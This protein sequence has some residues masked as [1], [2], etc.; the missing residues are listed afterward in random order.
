MAHLPSTAKEALENL[1]N[2]ADNLLAQSDITLGFAEWLVS[3]FQVLQSIYGVDSKEVQF[4]K[5]IRFQSLFTRILPLESVMRKNYRK[6]LM[7]AK[8]LLESLIQASDTSG[9]P[10]NQK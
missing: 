1:L 7:E 4:F 3:T 9:I 8:C 2:R 10:A 5:S 6:G